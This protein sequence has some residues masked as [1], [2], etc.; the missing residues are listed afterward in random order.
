MPSWSHALRLL[1]PTTTQKLVFSPVPE[2][3]GKFHGF[4]LPFVGAATN[5]FAF[6]AL[7]VPETK[8]VC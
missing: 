5:S 7:G 1:E 2:M 4:T 8:E 6:S 3:S